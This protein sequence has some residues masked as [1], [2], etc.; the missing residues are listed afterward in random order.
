MSAGTT[1]EGPGTPPG[2]SA[3]PDSPPGSSN[4]AGDRHL[5]LDEKRR[6]REAAR[7]EA[8]KVPVTFTWHGKSY[9]LPPELPVAFVDRTTRGLLEAGFAEILGADAKV[10]FDTKPSI[11]DLNE[12]SDFIRESYGI[13]LGE[14]PASQRS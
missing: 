8:A 11:D 13:G 9:T 12:L 2:P 7:S 14:A 10:F 3:P 4:G 1:Q 6:Q 5:D